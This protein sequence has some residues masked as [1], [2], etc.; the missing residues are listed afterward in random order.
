[1]E[2][3]PSLALQRSGVAKPRVSSTPHSVQASVKPAAARHG[4]AIAFYFLNDASC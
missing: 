1:M 2:A 4:E 3:V